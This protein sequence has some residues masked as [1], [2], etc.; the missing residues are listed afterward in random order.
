MG[1][2]GDLLDL[3]DRVPGWKEIRALPARVA[4][5]EARIAVLE[6]KR[7]AL[8]A[9]QAAFVEFSGALFKRKPSGGFHNAVYCPR[10]KTPTSDFPPGDRFNCTGCN[11]FSTF[12]AFELNTVLEQLHKENR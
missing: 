4:E 1:A 10:C 8:E 12:T 5:L 6:G 3:L 7:K 2:I 11:W 9:T